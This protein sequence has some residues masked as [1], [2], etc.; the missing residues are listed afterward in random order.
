MEANKD[1]SGLEIMYAIT[2]NYLYSEAIK[3]ATNLL[4]G[5]E[6]N[7]HRTVHRDIFL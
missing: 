5:A 6:F 7:I 2:C 3:A 1:C 4:H